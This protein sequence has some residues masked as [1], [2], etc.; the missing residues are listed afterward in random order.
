MYRGVGVALENRKVLLGW[1][2]PQAGEGLPK[3]LRRVAKEWDGRLA[4]R[5]V[6]RQNAYAT[7]CPNHVRG[8]GVAGAASFCE[9]DVACAFQLR[10]PMVPDQ[11]SDSLVVKTF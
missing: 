11:V 7:L 6:R 4:R 3:K 10:H 9:S 1:V 8:E 5:P 2:L